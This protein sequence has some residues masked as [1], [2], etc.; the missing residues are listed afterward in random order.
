[1]KEILENWKQ[2]ISEQEQQSAEKS[3]ETAESQL[4]NAVRANFDLEENTPKNNKVWDLVKRVATRFNL[5][6]VTNLARKQ[7][8]DTFDSSDGKKSFV[9]MVKAAT[10]PEFKKQ[11]DPN[12]SDDQ[13]LNIYED[14]YLPKI[15]DIIFNIPI[16]NMATSEAIKAHPEGAE[17]L[18]KRLKDDRNLGGFFGRGG[19]IKP[20]IGINVYAYVGDGPR[21][22]FPPLFRTVIEELAHAVDL[23]MDIP[24]SKILTKDIQK[25]L[26][27]QEETDVESKPFYD[28]M[29]QPK[30][31]VAKLKAIKYELWNSSDRQRYFDENGKI[32]LEQLKKYLEDPDNRERHNILRILNI[33]K[34]EDIGKVLDQI[35]KVDQQKNTQIA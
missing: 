29:A 7:F 5:N 3:L 4:D 30:E 23:Q 31:V 6:K 32:K 17:Y 21:V 35:V 33:K 12:A 18:T 15:K 16:V 19:G 34:I 25:A 8:Y 20:F 13:I 1:M 2:F 9:R 26:A 11:F 10:L 28:Y 27:S 24:F 14:Q 22:Y